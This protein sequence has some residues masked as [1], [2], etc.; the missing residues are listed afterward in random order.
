[1]LLQASAL[2]KNLSSSG[3]SDSIIW[4]L[5]FINFLT[6]L[7]TSF[8]KDLF[9]KNLES[10]NAIKIE[11]AKKRLTIYETAYNYLCILESHSIGV[12]KKQEYIEDLTNLQKFLHSNELYFK[13]KEIEAFN[14]A[15][16]YFTQIYSDWNKRNIDT[17]SKN[18]EKIKNLF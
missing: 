14:A 11:K 6:V 10:R 13:K 2:A 9:S 3:S 12:L 1:M 18:K 8:L 5:I 7:F 16:D 15:L 4:T 17:E